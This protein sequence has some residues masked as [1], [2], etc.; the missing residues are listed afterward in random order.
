M[1]GMISGNT[2]YGHEFLA[3]VIR[4]LFSEL[5]E[6]DIMRIQQLLKG[7]TQY[8][9]TW[10]RGIVLRGKVEVVRDSVVLGTSNVVTVEKVLGSAKEALCVRFDADKVKR[11]SFDD[12]NK[13][14]VHNLIIA[15]INMNEVE[16][17]QAKIGRKILVKGNITAKKEDKLKQQSRVTGD[18][19]FKLGEK[20]RG[21]FKT[22]RGKV[23]VNKAKSGKNNRSTKPF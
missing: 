19:V 20:R 12:I 18:T 7:L 15:D 6:A 13:L 1:T 10:V 17:V 21:A 8:D 22:A 23:K 4:S 3:G 2:T 5:G 11:C 9:I 16:V 14:A